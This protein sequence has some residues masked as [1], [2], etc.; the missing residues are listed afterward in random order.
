MSP[1]RHHSETH[2]CFV[3]MTV[4][5]NVWFFTAK[6]HSK[7]NW[8]QSKASSIL[9]DR[10]TQHCS[11]SRHRIGH[12]FHC[13]VAFNL[14]N[15]F[16]Q[17]QTLRSHKIIQS[18]PHRRNQITQHCSSLARAAVCEPVSVND[19]SAWCTCK[20]IIIIIIQRLCSFAH[21]ALQIWLLLLLL[22]HTSEPAEN[23]RIRKSSLRNSQCTVAKISRF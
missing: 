16:L 10:I 12:C 9:S 18:S 4:K 7:V 17:S 6:L 22:L 20:I 2:S 14:L 1:W 5:N 15:H 19:I 13:T 8:T 11:S 23:S 21:G 3:I